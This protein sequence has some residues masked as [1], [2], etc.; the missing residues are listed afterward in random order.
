MKPYT[1][2]VQYYETDMMGIAHHANYIHWMEEA[3]ID[4]MEQLG[5]PYAEMESNGIYSPVRSL[6][7][8]YRHPCTFNDDVEIAVSVAAFNGA[9]LVL[10]YEMKKGEQ[11]ICSATSEHA[12]LDEKGRILRLKRAV[13]EL[14]RKIELL[15]MHNESGEE[16]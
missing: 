8:E 14:S 7:C 16:K 9:R 2:K 12:F 10:R 13:P 6:A 15:C 1:R 4:F 5:Y 3:R 11:I